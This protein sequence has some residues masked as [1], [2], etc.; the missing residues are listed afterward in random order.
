MAKLHL[1]KAS[2]FDNKNT[3]SIPRRVQPKQNMAK[4]LSDFKPA[5]N[6]NPKSKIYRETFFLQIFFDFMKINFFFSL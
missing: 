4:Y 5:K 3:L 6:E 2:N 1:N